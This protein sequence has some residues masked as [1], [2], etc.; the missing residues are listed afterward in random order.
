MPELGPPLTGS[1]RVSGQGQ[2][3]LQPASTHQHS[4]VASITES[5]DTIKPVNKKFL[6]NS[7]RLT[8]TL[9]FYSVRIASCEERAKG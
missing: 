7:Y 2:L 8:S 5:P 4:A 1:P 9:M 6:R 3:W